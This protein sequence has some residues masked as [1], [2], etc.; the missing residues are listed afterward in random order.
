MVAALVH[1]ERARW[2][3]A[4]VPAQRERDERG[5]SGWHDS[6]AEWGRGWLR[7]SHHLPA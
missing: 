6:G 5:M 2:V 3:G 1:L 4:E 7:G